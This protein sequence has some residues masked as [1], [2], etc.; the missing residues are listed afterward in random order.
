MDNIRFFAAYLSLAVLGVTVLCAAIV[1]GLVAD[2][3]LSL[4]AAAIAAATT[5]QTLRRPAGRAMG[6]ILDST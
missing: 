2:G 1:A 3:L 6:A 4:P 5:F